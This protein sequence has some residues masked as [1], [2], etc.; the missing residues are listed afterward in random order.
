MA[1]AGFHLSERVIL[2]LGYRFIDMGKAESGKADTSGFTNNPP[3]GVDEL[4][5]HEFKVGLRIH[6]GG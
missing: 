5:A 4:T 2:D 6:F 3:L 1:G